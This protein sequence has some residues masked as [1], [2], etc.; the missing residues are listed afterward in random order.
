VDDWAA[1]SGLPAVDGVDLSDMLLKGAASPRADVPLSVLHSADLN[2]WDEY[3]YWHQGSLAAVGTAAGAEEVDDGGW[4]NHWSILDGV[5]KATVESEDVCWQACRDNAQ[6]MQAT[7]ESAGKHPKQCVLGGLNMTKRPIKNKCDSCVDHCYAKYGFGEGPAPT[8]PAPTPSPT[9]APQPTPK[10]PKRPTTWKVQQCD[11]LD[12]DLKVQKNI[13]SG[14]CGKLCVAEDGCVAAVF[15]QDTQSNNKL[16]TCRL[17]K[18][19]KQQIVDKVTKKTCF[20]PGEL[21]MPAPIIGTQAGIVVGDMKLIMGTEV[22][23][24]VWTGP[25]FPNAST[26]WTIDGVP[27]SFQC[28]TPY[29]I[30]CLFNVSADPTEHNDLAESQPEVAKRLLDRLRVYSA[31]YF[32]P[33]RGDHDPR[34]CKQVQKNKGFYGPWLELE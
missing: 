20:I 24:T 23:Q 21:D 27:P 9:P 26:P 2:K 19:A 25:T 7:F 3:D 8:P 15:E 14:D 4:C 13:A 17:K 29:K 33:D 28:S 1:A 5:K 12:K 32:N 22:S 11:I 10:P 30:G 6:C 16:G 34:A 18:S 31:T